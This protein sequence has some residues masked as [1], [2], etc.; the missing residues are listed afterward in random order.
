MID[1]TQPDADLEG[2]VDFGVCLRQSAPATTTRFPAM[3]KAMLTATRIGASEWAIRF[4]ALTSSPT[5]HVQTGPLHALGLVLPASTAARLMGPT[6]G[7]RVDVVLPWGDVAGDG[8]QARLLDAWRADDTDA[9]RLHALQESLRRVLA[10]E[11][12]RHRDS[13]ARML[14]HLEDAVGRQGARAAGVLGVS[15]RQLE[16][17]CRQWLGLAPKRLH[18]LTRFESALCGA[19]AT[20]RVPDV[21]AAL[22]AGYY[23]QSHLARDARRLAGAPMRELLAGARADAAWWPLATR[24]MTGERWR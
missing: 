11:P 14:R 13:R 16:R 8:E 18:R 20:R 9:S 17:R 10:R 23:D 12:E 19:L 1:W 15:E 2:A 22:A 4:H 3:A 5:T 24:R 7:A 21:D 6:T